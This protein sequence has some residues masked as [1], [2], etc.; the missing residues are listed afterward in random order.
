[1]NAAPQRAGHAGRLGRWS[2]LT[3]FFDA[4]TADLGRVQFAQI[5]SNDGGYGDP[6]R[7]LI[8]GGRWS[9]VLV[10][11][12]PYIFQRLTASYRGVPGLRFEQAAVGAAAATLP[13]YCLCEATEQERAKLPRWY[14]QIGSFSREHLLKHAPY[15]PGLKGRIQTIQV[16]VLTFAELCAR[17]ALDRLD[18]LHVDAE[19]HDLVIL[20]TI[21]LAAQGPRVLLFEHK[22]APAGELQEFLG[23]LHRHGYSTLT[24]A[25]DTL[26]LRNG[27]WRWRAPRSGVARWLLGRN[28]ALSPT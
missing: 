18:V 28:G 13:F 11:P 12:V 19:G 24:L 23:V 27:A 7:P 1:M 3:G 16:S 15:I 14:D 10:E 20:R 26:C 22:H 25:Q 21:D 6:L 8:E 2:T 5:G 4:L 9:G 17:H